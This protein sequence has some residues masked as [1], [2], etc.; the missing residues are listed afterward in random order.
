[1]SK[2]VEAAYLQKQGG[3]RFLL[4]VGFGLIYTFLLIGDHLPP[5]TYMTLQ[6][7]TIG[8]YLAGNGY[9]K[10]S[11]LKYANLKNGD[12]SGSKKDL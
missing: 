11:E 7:V 4:T 2:E 6:M 3:R 10:H 5:E 9:Q 1:M 12:P 8:A